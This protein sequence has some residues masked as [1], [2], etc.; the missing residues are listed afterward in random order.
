MLTV[1]GS[2]MAKSEGNFVTVRDALG[3]APG[4][5]IRLALLMTHY[6]EP[7]DW[8]EE[9]LREAEAIHGRLYRALAIGGFDL[10]TESSATNK[11]IEPI[12]DSLADDLN[13]HE[14]LNSLRA[15]GDAVYKTTDETERRELKG[16]LR[17]G[18]DLLG[19]LAREDLEDWLNP[20]LDPAVER[21]IQARADARQRR[22]FAEADRIRGELAAEGVILEDHPDGTTTPRRA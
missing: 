11:A 19:I 4:E 15:L 21:R 20:I 12:V 22:D 13:T 18:G 10:E 8:T 14:A 3:R 2:K 16:A 6:R 5:I 7:L 17:R 9:R 1:G